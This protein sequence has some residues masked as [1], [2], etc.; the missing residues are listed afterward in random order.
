MVPHLFQE[1]AWQQQE[2][3][4]AWSQYAAACTELYE[5]L[6]SLA[7]QFQ[8]AISGLQTLHT[9]Q[10]ELLTDWCRKVAVDVDASRM[11]LQQ[12]C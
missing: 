11:L 3:G 4:T 5:E 6:V 10:K 12:V 7:D 8:V 9:S 1:T 2:L